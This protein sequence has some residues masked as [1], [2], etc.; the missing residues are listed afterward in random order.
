MK[1]SLFGVCLSVM[2][3]GMWGCVDDPVEEPACTVNACNGNISMLCIN[4]TVIPKDCGVAG[5]NATTGT[6][7]QTVPQQCTVNTCSGSTANLCVGG[8]I[9]PQDCGAAG[10]NAATG[11]CNSAVQPQCTANTCS[12]NTANLCVSG[13]IVPQDCGAA[14]C[15]AATGT[16]NTQE[17]P[18][19]CDTAAKQAEC[20]AA[21]Q[22]FDAVSCACVP[23]QP[24]DTPV[25]GASCDSSSY[26][27]GCSSDGT[28]R[29]Y[30]GNDGKLVEK[31]CNSGTSCV[32][33][34]N[35]SSTCETTGDVADCAPGGTVYCNK[36]CKADGSEGYYYS[37]GEVHIMTC[38]NND[39]TTASGKVEC[40]GGS[41]PS[42]P[43]DNPVA[44]ASCDKNSYEGGC[45]SDGTKRYYCGNDGKLVEKSCNS[46]TSCVVKGNNSSTC[47][48]TGDVADCEPGGTVYCNKVCKADGSEGYYYS[49]GEVHI[50]TCANNDCT[51]ASG[52][53][54]CGGGSTPSEPGDNPVAG[55]SCDSSSYEG[56]CSSDGTKRYY[57]GND[58]KLVE[59]SCNSGTSCVVKG[60]NSSTCESSG[61]VAD[62]EPGGTVYCNKVCK[63][64][65]SE[66]YYYSKGEVHIV[67][68][69]NNDCTTASGKVECGGGSTP[70]VP[71][72][73]PVA[74]ASC[75][76]NSYEGGCSSDGTKRY[77]C[78]NDGKLVEKSCNSGTSCVVKG[79]NSSICEK[80][81]SPEPGDEP[82]AGASCDPTTYE[83]GC[84]SDG[85]KRYYCDL[86]KKV[87]VEK[88]C[89]DGYTCTV[90]G[91]N[92]SSCVKT[93]CSGAQVTTGGVPDKSCCNVGSYQV[94]CINGNANALI[95]SGGIVKQWE[96]ANSQCSVA[97]NKVT[98]PNPNGGGSN[99]CTGSTVT[100]GGVVGQC[101]DTENY[102]PAGCD[103][104]SN[105]GLRCS[106]GI[107][108]EWTCK[109]TQKCS[110][111]FA[112]KWYSCI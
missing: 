73:N 99:S 47:E 103:A 59:K 96:C 60:N 66:G 102:N 56:G 45:S 30:C 44:G 54:E 81:G 4:G 88:S 21:G 2:A 89:S 27:G 34:G 28:K 18:S 20:A 112:K 33:K 93:S 57:C 16:C 87:L 78:G 105:S 10:C 91:K 58:G 64:D 50:V 36:V 61:E 72:D 9:V 35:N 109:E 1:K 90:N 70:S 97:N 83:G 94:S 104:Y 82:V 67:T 85:T 46:G 22:N 55:A 12:G 7:N 75:D 23:K 62:C 95:C 110:Y 52:K 101:C 32:V 100:E 42:E 51:T 37:K 108:K 111:D 26:E 65:G 17:P 15:N 48:T 40:G 31:S 43:G 80:S 71:G 63:A 3:L 39:C 11:T 19:E 107:I 25:A 76:K 77:Y 106:N 29:Y 92:S 14:G 49:K 38:A 68:C 41:T 6:C 79:N 5:C 74:G 13:K 53:V 84:K 69:A 98:C 8:T 24:G 86:N